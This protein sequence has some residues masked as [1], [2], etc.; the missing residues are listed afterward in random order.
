[1]RNKIL[2]NKLLLLPLIFLFLPAFRIWLPVVNKG[3]FIYPFITLFF[4]IILLFKDKGKVLKKIINVAKITPFKYLIITFALIIVNTLF[5]SIIGIAH[6]SSS[7]YYIFMN[8][9][10]WFAPI[11][12]YFIYITDTYISYKDIYKS[13]IFLF[14]LNLILGCISWLGMYFD[15][16]FI[17]NLFDFFANARIINAAHN[18]DL[19]LGISNFYAFG[20]PRLDNLFE[21]PSFYARFLFLFLPMIYSYGNSKLKLYKSNIL[22]LV[23]KKTIIPL[24][25]L[26]LILTLSPIFL[27]FT[28]IITL[29]YYRQNLSKLFKKYIVHSIVLTIIFILLIN[30]I[31][32]ENT[33]LS[34]I[35]NVLTNVKSFED[36]III[37]PS[38]ATRLVSFINEFIVFTHYPL[39]GVGY[40]NLRY[41]M[42]NQF[43]NSP[44][45]L[46]PENT[47]WLKYAIQTKENMNFNKGF[48]YYFLAENG[49]IIFSIFGYFYYKLIKSIK[50]YKQKYSI[51]KNNFTYIILRGV[52][53][54]LISLFIMLF[55]TISF[56]TIDIYIIF[57]L[58]I[59]LIFNIKVSE[60]KDNEGIKNENSNIK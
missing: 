13:F 57:I 27:I 32:V 12:L 51:Y 17:N 40:E 31:D 24:T 59:S 29:I 37:E 50:S 14:W 44:V 49:I 25:I 30:N 7:L 47:I 10:L 36:F 53:G 20:L 46:T 18:N 45:P 55:Y 11:V 9:F 33:Y 54:C 21:E 56:N 26:S 35:F 39:T 43:L 19:D 6:L 34:R 48:I 28:V 52:D 42:Q 1:M 41:Y 60:I 22:N 16:N 3:F 8:I 4:L 38:L 58:I 15:I 2:K 5:L 23:I